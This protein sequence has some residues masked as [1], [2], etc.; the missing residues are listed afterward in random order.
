MHQ[1]PAINRSITHDHPC[2][3]SLFLPLRVRVRWYV[4]VFGD[5]Q[6]HSK[7]CAL[8]TASVHGSEVITAIE[9]L[10]V[11]FLAFS[12]P[13]ELF[14]NPARQRGGPQVVD[15]GV[16]LQDDGPDLWVVEVLVGRVRV[17]HDPLERSHHT[18]RLEAGADVGVAQDC[19]QQRVRRLVALPLL[20]VK[21]IFVVV[22][23]AIVFL[24]TRLLIL[25]TC[26]RAREHQPNECGRV[27]RHRE[28][29]A[30]KPGDH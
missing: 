21:V 1:R 25:T 5:W 9:V 8:P 4:C 16:D 30:N 6:V 10:K 3:P 17:L 19:L 18:L 26:A 12:E 2:S 20:A 22:F 11:V 27:R 15:E 29:R 14:A 24:A 28:W 13:L 23:F 7:R